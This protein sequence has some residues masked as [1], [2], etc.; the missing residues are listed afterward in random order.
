MK[1]LKTKNISKFSISDDALIY[2]PSGRY[3]MDGVGALRIPAG[4]T[5]ERPDVNADVHNDPYGY[6]RY[7]RTTNTIEAYIYNA[8]SGIG[9][10]ETIKAPGERAI[11]KQTLG[12]G[13]GVDTDFG[14]LTIKPSNSGLASAG[15]GAV[16]DYPIIVLVENVPQIS[17]EN[18]TLD[19]DYMGTGQVW[20]KFNTFVDTGKYITVYHGYGN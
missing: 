16:Y 1:Y 13:N 12:P 19:F 4:S 9:V 15:S 18:Y 7:N 10:W 11:V 5:A 14:P 20:I 17:N 8:Q 6:L 3:V 2:K